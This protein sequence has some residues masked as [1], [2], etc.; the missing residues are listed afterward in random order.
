M[1]TTASNPCII[2]WAH[3]RFGKLDDAPDT[4][5]LI[6]LVARAAIEDAGLDPADIDAVFLG[7][8]NGGF[9]RQDFPASLVFQAVPELRFK[10]ATR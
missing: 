8:F 6:G 1:E 3:S 4:E 5:A 10:P 9:V 7:Q 2:G